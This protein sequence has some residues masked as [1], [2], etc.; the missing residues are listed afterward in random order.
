[1]GQQP[2]SWALLG[3]ELFLL[4]TEVFN[5]LDR[6]GRAFLTLVP[7]VPDMLRTQNKR[8]SDGDELNGALDTVYTPI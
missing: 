5:W 4:L 3:K 7:F 6:T 1:M 8:C 2:A